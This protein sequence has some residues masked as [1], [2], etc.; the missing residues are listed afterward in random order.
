MAQTLKHKDSL[1]RFEMLEIGATR[2]G[3]SK[4]RMRETQLVGTRRLKHGDTHVKA[5]MPPDFIIF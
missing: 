2:R 1:S 5:T 3:H 4:R